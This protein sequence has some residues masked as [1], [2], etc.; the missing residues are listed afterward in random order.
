MDIKEL[1]PYLEDCP[2]LPPFF[3]EL[4]SSMNRRA[5]FHDYYKPWFYMITMLSNPAIGKL[6]EIQPD[7]LGNISSKRNEK[8]LCIEAAKQRLLTT[9][10]SIAIY[11]SVV[12]PDHF[13]MIFSVLE[14]TKYCLGDYISAFKTFSTQELAKIVPPD[15]NGKKISFFLPEF[16]DSICNSSG[17]LDRMKNYIKDNPRRLYMKK[18]N[19]Q[20]F[21][22]H[23]ITAVDNMSVGYLAYGNIDLLKHWNKKA[24]RISRSTAETEMIRIRHDLVNEIRN[25]C[26]LVSPF[27][28]RG[29]KAI[30][31]ST[32]DAGGMAIKIIPEGFSERFKPSGMEFEFCSQGRL[33]IIGSCDYNAYSYTMS[34]PLAERLNSIA[35]QIA[36]ADIIRYH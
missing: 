14:R 25:G 8:G 26:V 18:Q 33:L 12:M 32:L 3:K 5:R 30:Y 16:N 29:E 2:I 21:T 36:D 9:F 6:A 34:K 1:S 17:Q 23:E 31:R 22:F 11:N 13:H 4:K 15:S 24:I 10:P 27:I 35:R 28:S 19:K 7:N 20:Y